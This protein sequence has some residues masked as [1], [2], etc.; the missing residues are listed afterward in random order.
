MSQGSTWKHS[1]MSSGETGYMGERT[2]KPSTGQRWTQTESFSGQRGNTAR[3]RDTVEVRDR[4][5]DNLD[6]VLFGLL[7]PTCAFQG[8]TQWE[9]QESGDTNQKV[10]N[11]S[12][13]KQHIDYP[14]HCGAWYSKELMMYW[15]KPNSQC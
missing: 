10:R 6:S 13:H 12:E 5:V 4:R 1:K 2:K 15:R 3:A 7:S 11:G 9:I 8:P 14:S